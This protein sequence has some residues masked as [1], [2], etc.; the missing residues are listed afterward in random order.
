MFFGLIQVKK[1]NEIMV[2]EGINQGLFLPTGVL[3]KINEV[4]RRQEISEY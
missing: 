3:L 4:Y 1:K 2:E